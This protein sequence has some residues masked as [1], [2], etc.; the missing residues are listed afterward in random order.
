METVAV[1][2]LVTLCAVLSAVSDKGQYVTL[3]A[4]AML[5]TEL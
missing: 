2:V 4:Y 3:G 1:L 5:P